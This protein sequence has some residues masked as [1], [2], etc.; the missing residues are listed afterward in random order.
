MQ[1]TFQRVLAM[2]AA[3]PLCL[4]VQSAGGQISAEE[5]G[6]DTGRST[7]WE[8]SGYSAYIRGYA[9]TPLAVED[10]AVSGSSFAQEES[11]GA[12][13]QQEY[14]GRTDVLVWE[15]GQGSVG[16]RITVPAKRA[17]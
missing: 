7:V 12:V 9:D 6:T 3:V 5:A 15:S 10:V 2:V 1:K 17:L 14:N 13:I 11:S 4:G 8:S 16:W